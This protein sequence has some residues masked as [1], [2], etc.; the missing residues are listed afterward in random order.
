MSRTTPAHV[1]NQP[2]GLRFSVTTDGADALEEA[3]ARLLRDYTITE[4]QLYERR[5]V[6]ADLRAVRSQLDGS[7]E[8]SVCPTC[9]Q[10]MDSDVRARLRV[11]ITGHVEASEQ[12]EHDLVQRLAQ[13]KAEVALGEFD[14]FDERSSEESDDGLDDFPAVVREEITS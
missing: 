2:S 1:P 10:S 4:A 7:G 9:A 13:I 3:N 5:L 8:P 12:D 11:V 6:L 14:E